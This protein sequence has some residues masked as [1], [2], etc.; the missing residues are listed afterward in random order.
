MQADQGLLVAW[1]G[2]QGTVKREA[3]GQH[4][5]M[6]LWDADDLLDALFDTYGS[7]RD[8]VRSRLPLQRVWVL[9]QGEE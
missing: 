1:R 9:V 2:F 6:V 4:F 8:D 5:S 7:I 3:R